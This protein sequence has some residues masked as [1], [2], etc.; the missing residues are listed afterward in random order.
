MVSSSKTRPF[1]PSCGRWGWP[2]CTCAGLCS[3]RVVRRRARASAV[4]GRRPGAAPGYAPRG[5]IFAKS[6][7]DFSSFAL[8]GERART[9]AGADSGTQLSSILQHTASRSRLGF[10]T[11][12]YAAGGCSS[13]LAR[14]RLGRDAA[15]G[16]R[17]PRTSSSFSDVAEPSATVAVEG[18]LPW[19]LYRA[20]HD[21]SESADTGASRREVPFKRAEGQGEGADREAAGVTHGRTGG[22]R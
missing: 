9:S 12:S 2:G 21:V 16:Q 17:P 10:P 5:P 7:C 15:A 8:S 3:V 11:S 20:A 4:H 22:A 18:A 1:P 6:K 14:G 13:T 19:L